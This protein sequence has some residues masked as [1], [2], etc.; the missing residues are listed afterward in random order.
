VLHPFHS[1]FDFFVPSLLGDFDGFGS[2]SGSDFGSGRRQ[3]L[4]KGIN[5]ALYGQRLR[6]KR[7]ALLFAV[8]LVRED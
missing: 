5:E 3:W 1:V 6:T 4:R 2:L 7:S 8:S